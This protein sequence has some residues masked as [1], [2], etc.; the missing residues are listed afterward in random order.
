M[1]QQGQQPQN[2][3]PTPG[4]SPAAVEPAPPRDQ[5]NPRKKWLLWGT[6]AVAVPVLAL[7]TFFGMSLMRGSESGAA[8]ADEAASTFVKAVEANDVT[9][10]TQ[11]VVPSES[12]GMNSLMDAGA[13]KAQEG[14]GGDQQAS[15][16]DLL[17]GITLD[18]SELKMKVTELDVPADGIK[19][20]EF[21][22]GSITA[23]YDPKKADPLMKEFIEEMGGTNTA[24][25]EKTSV[26]EI[27]KETGKTPYIVAVKQGDSWYFSPLYTALEHAAEDE[28]VK[29]VAGAVESTSYP[30]AEKAASAFVEAAVASGNSGDPDDFL[31]ALSPYE[32]QL[33]KRYQP[34][35]EESADGSSEGSGRV[36][37]NEFA[38]PTND[39]D[40]VRVLPKDVQIGVTEDGGPEQIAT[41]KDGCV[42]A[43]GE[44]SCSESRTGKLVGEHAKGLVVREGENGWNV[45]Y[46]PSLI[47]IATDIAKG[48]SKADLEDAAQEA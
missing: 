3:Q 36:I 6:A 17:K 47:A 31:K 46:L 30:S 40:R 48:A 39:G 43:E 7:G 14:E 21:T 9:R 45:E 25:S 26:A 23:S 34:L 11:F 27:R 15:P 2:G 38:E 16:N 5:G 41:F 44:S 29:P 19:K 18:T 42:M 22:G 32:A 33:Y 37:K 24:E 8:S 1:D 35:A 28:G 4:A 10:A 13:K 20:V 12:S